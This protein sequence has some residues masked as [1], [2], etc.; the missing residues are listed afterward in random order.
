MHI[1]LFSY[2]LVLLRQFRQNVVVLSKLTHADKK[3]YILQIWA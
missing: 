2:Y 1:V 3:V